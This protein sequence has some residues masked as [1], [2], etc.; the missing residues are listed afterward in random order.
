MKRILAFLLAAALIGCL[1]L[2]VAAETTYT[3]G[4]TVKIGGMKFKVPEGLTAE[5]GLG[6][7]ITIDFGP[8]SF[9]VIRAI[10]I[11]EYKSEFMRRYMLETSQPESWK[12]LMTDKNE[13]LFSIE[14]QIQKKPVEFEVKSFGDGDILAVL[15]VF[16]QG[17]YIYSIIF[18]TMDLT[19]DFDLS[20]IIGQTAISETTN[21]AMNLNTIV[22]RT[23]KA[24]FD[25]NEMVLFESFLKSIKF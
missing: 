2:P 3:S 24:S 1:A 21:F 10:D 5:E 17:D 8:D 20:S 4:E 22:G 9:A 11:S 13:Y 18:E 12:M 15:G 23:A 16:A 25:D 6:K 19:T 14:Y 7:A